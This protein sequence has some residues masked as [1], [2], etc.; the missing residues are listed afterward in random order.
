MRTL[1]CRCV[2]REQLYM[3]HGV[4]SRRPVGHSERPVA[5][6]W[7]PAEGSVRAPVWRHSGARLLCP[8]LLG[9]QRE[10]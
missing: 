7:R 5:Q 3:Q 4:K 9:H 6:K 2:L 8:R 1:G 10:N